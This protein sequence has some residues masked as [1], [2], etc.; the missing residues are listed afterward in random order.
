LAKVNRAADKSPDKVE[1]SSDDEVDETMLLTKKDVY[2]KTVDEC[3]HVKL[4]RHHFK[5]C[6]MEKPGHKSMLY[7]TKN[8]LS[9]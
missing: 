3:L 8:P 5:A 4:T 6:G 9:Q 1:E 2:A 7:H